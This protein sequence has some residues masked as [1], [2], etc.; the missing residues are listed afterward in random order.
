VGLEVL[1]RMADALTWL[2]LVRTCALEIHAGAS[3]AELRA[4]MRCAK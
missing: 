1:W 2:N 4:R 3:E